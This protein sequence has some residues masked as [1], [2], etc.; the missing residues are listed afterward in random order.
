MHKWWD[1]THIVQYEPYDLATD[2][3]LHTEYKFYT[4]PQLCWTLLRPESYL[5]YL[6]TQNF[7]SLL[8]SHFWVTDIVKDD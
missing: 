7:E 2:D 6:Y 1:V 5:I 3:A 4:E 8:Y